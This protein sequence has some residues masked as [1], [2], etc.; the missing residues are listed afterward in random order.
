ME[1]GADVEN[2][3]PEGPFRC[4]AADPPW[5]Y[6][7]AGGS[8]MPAQMV[9]DGSRRMKA[10]NQW[11]Y[12]PMPMDEILALPVSDVVGSSAHLYLWVTN[13]FIAEGL[14]VMEAWGFNYKT[15]LTW[16]KTHGDAPIRVSMKSGYYFRG[17]TEH[18][19]FGVRGSCPPPDGLALPT[20][21]LW[22]R[23]AR[24]SAKPA[25]FYRDVA[26]KMSPPPGWRCS[27]ATI[28]RA[29]RCGATRSGNPTRLA[30]SLA[31]SDEW[32]NT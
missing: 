18:V 30:C 19:L 28:G 32:R 8:A 7:N 25:E 17:A 16:T 27:L 29:G 11:S 12:A 20:G 24:H 21:Y 22:P 15:M 6:E 5:P 13:L 9:K 3:L 31:W 4:V 26:E 10:V 2:P 1:S 14:K 23:L